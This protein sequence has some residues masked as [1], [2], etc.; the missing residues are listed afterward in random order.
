MN[1]FLKRSVIY[2]TGD[3]FYINNTS[4]DDDI[5][6]VAGTNKFLFMGQTGHDTVYLYKESPTDI[7]T[8]MFVDPNELFSSYTISGSDL[9]IGY[10]GFSYE[11]GPY[12]GPTLND[13]TITIKDF[14]LGKQFDAYESM[15]GWV[16]TNAEMLAYGNKSAE[17]HSDLVT[18]DKHDT[19]L[20]SKDKDLWIFGN[21]DNKYIIGGSDNETIVSGS[22]NH[23]IIGGAGDDTLIASNGTS[24]RFLFSKGDGNDT[25]VSVTDPN[26]IIKEQNTVQFLDVSSTD[27]FSVRLEEKDQIGGRTS[28]NVKK[29]SLKIQYSD[30]DSLTVSTDLYSTS[31]YEGFSYQFKDKTLSAKELLDQFS[32]KNTTGIGSPSSTIKPATLSDNNQ[33][34][35]SIINDFIRNDK[36]IKEPTSIHD[37]NMYDVN[38]QNVPTFNDLMAT[39]GENPSQIHSNIF[40][41]YAADLY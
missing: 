39:L 26:L 23:L 5:Y 24:N 32:G 9:T 29:T 11:N 15:I 8:A 14:F 19:V 17:G 12:G 25:L 35:D 2:G 38:K 7:N 37:Q 6:G 18:V 41:R 13:N 22:G 4:D 21:S 40:A 36:N 10:S 27:I 16:F 20:T 3:D 1:N 34:T 28:Q 31:F 30:H 33:F